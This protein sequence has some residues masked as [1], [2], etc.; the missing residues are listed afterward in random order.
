MADEN[1]DPDIFG[2]E[3]DAYYKMMRETTPGKA[4]RA[5]QFVVES[6]E[7]LKNVEFRNG[8]K[9]SISAFS[10]SIPGLGEEMLDTLKA[11]CS[12]LALFEDEGKL[13]GE[14]KDFF[15]IGG[16]RKTRRSRSRRGKKS[17]RKRRLSRRHR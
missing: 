6:T 17:L 3:L 5:L 9:T 4:Q 7:L 10:K 8:M 11:L 2:D 13:P 1:M 12:K 15:P 14:C 16:S